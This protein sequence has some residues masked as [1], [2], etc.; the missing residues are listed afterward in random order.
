MGR[1]NGG[2]FLGINFLAQGA[3]VNGVSSEYY[4]NRDNGY[5]KRPRGMA[6]AFAKRDRSRRPQTLATALLRKY[7]TAIEDLSAVTQSFLWAVQTEGSISHETI[8]GA[9]ERCL[10]DLARSGCDD[11]D[12][13]LVAR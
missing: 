1:I 12:A 10:L 2:I 11:F 4:Q 3:R 5:Q 6:C 7:A 8:G 9:L 13:R